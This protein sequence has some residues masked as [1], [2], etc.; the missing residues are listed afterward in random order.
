MSVS[1]AGVS[2]TELKSS[3]N[4]ITISINCWLDIFTSQT[5]TSLCNRSHSATR[6][7]MRPIFLKKKQERLYSS[8]CVVLKVTGGV[9]V[10]GRIE[11]LHPC[12]W[13]LSVVR[14]LADGIKQNNQLH[15]SFPGSTTLPFT[16]NINAYE[17]YVVFIILISYIHYAFI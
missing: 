9:W 13:T 5:T 3:N 12:C 14:L 15:F 6:R 10:R 1:M 8:H 4:I 17:V 2:T 7:V 11:P 16:Y